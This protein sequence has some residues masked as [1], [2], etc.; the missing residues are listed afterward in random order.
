[1]LCHCGSHPM[2]TTH[3]VAVITVDDDDVVRDDE[4]QIRPIVPTTHICDKNIVDF[5]EDFEF[6]IAR[7]HKN[8]TAF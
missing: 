8:H 3:A 4:V 1:M 6:W 7:L 5:R 2:T